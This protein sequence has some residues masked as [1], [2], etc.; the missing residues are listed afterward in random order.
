LTSFPSIQNFLLPQYNEYS[1]WYLQG[2]KDI[3]IKARVANWKREQKNGYP[4][5]DYPTEVLE[6]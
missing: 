3:D 1:S 4:F 2:I 6:T 5:A